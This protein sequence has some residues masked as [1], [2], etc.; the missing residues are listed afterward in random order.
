MMNARKGEIAYITR[1]RAIACIAIV[2]L[3]TFYGAAAGADAGAYV[4]DMLVR[5]LMLWAVPSFVMITGTLLLDPAREVDYQ[6][7]FRKYIPRV[8]IALF[9][10]AVL[11]E[12]CDDIADGSF[13]VASPFAGLLK[14]CTGGSWNHMWYIY[15]VL[16]LYLLMPF[17]RKISAALSRIDAWYLLGVFTLFLCILPF[18]ETFAGE[19]AF[20]ICIY[21]VYPLYLFLGFSLSKGF[22]QLPRFVWALLIAVGTLGVI[23]CTILEEDYEIATG[24]S[25]DSPFVLMQSAGIFALCC[26]G[27][28]HEPAWL[29]AI[30]H[31]IGACSFGVYLLHM[32]PLKT[33]LVYLHWNPYEHGGAAMVLLLTIGIFLVTFGVVF[34]LKKIPGVRRIL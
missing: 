27:K 34:L 15:L 9:A 23:I 31:Q 20:Y 6:K 30:F 25:Y 11:F 22:L 13:S 24:L 1:L 3:H 14:A 17:Y 16:A 19:I 32:L 29:S 5:N 33:V 18:V 12:I 7:L 21:T 28:G 2:F 26:S 8:V 4:V 10:F